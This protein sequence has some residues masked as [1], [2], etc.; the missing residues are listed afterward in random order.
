[1][2]GFYLSRESYLTHT[3]PELAGPAVVWPF[4]ASVVCCVRNI[5][6]SIIELTDRGFELVEGGVARS[7]A[8]LTRCHLTRQAK[9]RF[10]VL[11]ETVE[12]DIKYHLFTTTRLCNSI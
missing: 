6:N 1:M 8:P 11:E 7:L 4:D 5:R 3:S 12:L 10:F 2:K 9:T